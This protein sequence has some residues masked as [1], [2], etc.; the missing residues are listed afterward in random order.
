[1]G[2]SSRR[3]RQETSAM[4]Y[5]ERAISQCQ[6]IRS[7]KTTLVD[8]EHQLFIQSDILSS[9]PISRHHMFMNHEILFRR[10]FKPQLNHNLHQLRIWQATSS[11]KLTRR[12]RFGCQRQAYLTEPA[13]KCSSIVPKTQDQGRVWTHSIV[14]CKCGRHFYTGRV[15]IRNAYVSALSSLGR[16]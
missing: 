7:Q 6:M 2:V 4:W 15:F 11:T 9:L 12:P 16:A 8:G 5:V 14:A 13:G 3:G 10:E 1:M